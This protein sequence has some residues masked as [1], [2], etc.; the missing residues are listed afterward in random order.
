MD[1]YI[2]IPSHSQFTLFSIPNFKSYFHFPFPWVPIG[3][4]S[5]PGP[6]LRNFVGAQFQKFLYDVM[7]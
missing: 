6:I 5:F 3:I 7:H 2:P 1:F 4:F